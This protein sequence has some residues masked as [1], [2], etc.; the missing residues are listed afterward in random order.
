MRTARV[1]LIKEYR[2]KLVPQISVKET[3]VETAQEHSK[4]VQ[5]DAYKHKFQ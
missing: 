3:P 2:Y 1:Q 5:A 4:L